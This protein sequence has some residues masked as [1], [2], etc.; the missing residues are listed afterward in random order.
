MKGQLY[1][2]VGDDYNLVSSRWSFWHAHLV[3]SEEIDLEDWVAIFDYGNNVILEGRIKSVAIGVG[4]YD[5]YAIS[6]AYEWARSKNIYLEYD[7]LSK[8]EVKKSVQKV[9]DEVKFETLSV[10]GV[11][12]EN[13]DIVNVYVSS[14]DDEYTVARISQIEYSGGKVA[15]TAYGSGYDLTKVYVRKIYYNVAPEDIVRDL[16]ESNSN[17]SVVAVPT[18]VVWERFPVDGYAYDAIKFIAEGV[19]YQLMIEGDILYFEPF[20]YRVSGKVINE[21]FGEFVKVGS[22][23]DKIV[24]DLYLYGDYLTYNTSET[25]TGDGITTEFETKYVVYGNVQVLIDGLEVP[26]TEYEVK[27]ED[28][29]LIFKTAPAD[30]S[31]IQVTYSYQLP[32]FVHI[33][34]DESIAKYGRRGKKITA[35]FIDT[36][37]KARDYGFMYIRNFADPYDYAEV[38]TTITRAVH[39]VDLGHVYQVSYKMN[40]FSE[41]LSLIEITLNNKGLATLKFGEFDFDIIEWYKQVEDRLKQLEKLFEADIT[42]TEYKPLQER[43][44]IKAYD[45]L[46]KKITKDLGDESID[47]TITDAMSVSASKA[48]SESVDVGLV[49]EISIGIKSSHSETVSVGVVDGDLH[50]YI[51]S[52]VGESISVGIDD[53]IYIVIGGGVERVLGVMQL[54]IS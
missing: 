35:R 15:I 33:A 4:Y 40:G 20:G 12:F 45:R 8:V 18:G 29:K 43:I 23:T 14:Y 5:V 7:E 52:R 16:V 48:I 28:K 54:G 27:R 47:I 46:R 41:D 10:L 19:E 9:V 53:K 3:V 13:G 1:F 31:T 51:T 42:L 39:D 24:N 17:L 11:L 2:E 34:D 6:N 21:T 30:G 26:A 49:D 22:N 37:E 44:G 25:F 32:I 38:K 36:F 50:K